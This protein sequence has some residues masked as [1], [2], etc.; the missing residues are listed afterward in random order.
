[1]KTVGL[2][3]YSM[4]YMMVLIFSLGMILPNLLFGESGIR[5][6]AVSPADATAP[7]PNLER[8]NNYSI[9]IENVND[10]CDEEIKLYNL[11]DII[12]DKR[13]D[14]ASEKR[15]KSEFLGFWDGA[16][17]VNP[18]TVE[19]VDEYAFDQIIGIKTGE[20]QD[21][22]DFQS[23][24]MNLALCDTGPK[25]A[26]CCDVFDGIGCED[27]TPLNFTIEVEA[28]P[29]PAAPGFDGRIWGKVMKNGHPALANVELKRPGIKSWCVKGEPDYGKDQII[30][31]QWSVTTSDGLNDSLDRGH[32]IFDDLPMGEF[33]VYVRI[34]GTQ[35]DKIPVTLTT[36]QKVAQV[37]I[38]L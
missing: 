35:S 8:I 3:V 4:R 26:T 29:S 13:E 37:D 31:L 14:V 27:D 16:N 33:E 7:P 32:Y 21:G 30:Q 17:Y 5:I 20:D 19:V 22:C 15:G 38:E 25:C 6:G 36:N 12:N 11:A 24:R 34:D 18:Y 28:L 9:R 2:Q 23:F 1:M 10:V